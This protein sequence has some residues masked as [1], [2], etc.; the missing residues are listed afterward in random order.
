MTKKTFAHGMIALLSVICLTSAA[1]AQTNWWRTYGGPSDDQGYSVQQTVDG[2]YVVTGC[3]SAFTGFYV[4]KTNAS[5]DTLWTRTY[6]RDMIGASEGYSV[7]QTIDGGYVIAGYNLF[8]GR[9]YVDVYLFKTNASG[10][11]LWTKGYGGT[12]ED[13][14]FSVQQTS[15]GGYIITGYTYSFGTGAPVVDDV[16][17][18]KTDASGD[19]I[20]TRTYG[21]GNY[22]EGHSVQQTTDGGYIIA[23][24]TGGVNKDVSLVKTNAQGDAIWT[25][26]YGGSRDDVGYSVWQTT[27]SGYLVAGR[28]CSYGPGTPGDVPNVYLIRTD[29]SGDTAWTTTYG[30]T[31]GDV[32]NSVQQTSDSGYIIGGRTKSYGVGGD[33]YLIK[34][35]AS[36]YVS[37]E[38]PT[39]LHPASKTRFLVQPNPFASLARVSGHETESF[40]LS[41]VTGRQVAVCGD[42]RI[43]EG[44]RPGV[45]FPAPVVKSGSSPATT[46]IKSAR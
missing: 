32:G 21:G 37:L 19:T 39:T 25:G 33:V 16:Y 22:D 14:G 35:D 41:D 11:T 30:G 27:D 42:D 36:G 17:L 26:T 10:D 18:V 20:W 9:P 23:G 5:G 24:S 45:Y 43:G 13:V 34:T 28:T 4:V 46:I 2:G 3:A 15:D 8:V 1:S 7:Q 44:L 31:G 6:G 12:D 38:E 40:V 29:A